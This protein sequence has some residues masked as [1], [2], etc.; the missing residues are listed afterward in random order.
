M[1]NLRTISVLLHHCCGQVSKHCCL[2]GM[3]IALFLHLLRVV[4]LL[5]WNILLLNH[6]FS[7]DCGC[8]VG[9]NIR[10]SP[11]SSHN[12]RILTFTG[13]HLSKGKASLECPLP[14]LDMGHIKIGYLIFCNFALPFGQIALDYF[15]KNKKK[16]KLR[17]LVFFIFSWVWGNWNGELVD[18]LL[19][20]KADGSGDETRTKKFCPCPKFIGSLCF[21]TPNI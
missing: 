1:C 17:K 13:H 9:W 18:T 3:P 15:L 16:L 20:L 5:R 2:L 10:Y 19:G 4:T 21:R 7:L 14:Q 11:L 8:F 6:I 12:H